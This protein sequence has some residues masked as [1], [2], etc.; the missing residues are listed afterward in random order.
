M[1][2]TLSLMVNTMTGP[3]GAVGPWRSLGRGEDNHLK[4]GLSWLQPGLYPGRE[5]SLPGL[6][7]D[8]ESMNDRAIG[9]GGGGP[10]TNEHI[11][12]GY[13]EVFGPVISF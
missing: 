7:G 1:V 9:A 3:G 5:R 12:S 11:Y 4:S 10:V 13:G 6:I 2:A 8:S